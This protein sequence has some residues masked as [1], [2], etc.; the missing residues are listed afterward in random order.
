MEG[1]T[2]SLEDGSTAVVQGISHVLPVNNIQSEI[3]SVVNPNIV[4][5]DSTQVGGQP[6][7][8]EDGTTAFLHHTPK[9]GLQAIQ[10]EDGTTAYITHP[11]AESLFGDAQIT[12]L[13]SSTLSLDQLATQVTVDQMKEP[14]LES[15]QTSTSPLGA[16]TSVVHTVI[17][18]V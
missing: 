9:E 6:I 4:L 3:D 8:L 12:N 18:A 2:I 10:L 15:L 16:N 17:A 13:D 14:S 1:Q 11:S 7:Q 5:T